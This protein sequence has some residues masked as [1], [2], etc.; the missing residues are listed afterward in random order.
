MDTLRPVRKL[1]SGETVYEGYDTAQI[2]ENG[3]VITRRAESDPRYTE[4]HCSKCGA[5]TV[6]ACASCSAKIR[7]HLHGTMPSMHEEP[8]PN[9]CH[10]CGKPYPWI[11]QKLLAATVLIEEADGLSDSEK[12][13]LTKSLDDLVRDVPATDLPVHVLAQFLVLALACG[14]WELADAVHEIRQARIAFDPRLELV[15]SVPSQ[16]PS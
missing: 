12:A 8:A 16:S 6:M 1:G 10:K 11:E 3:H 7:G 9:F 13:A 4:D 5:K 15:Q 14:L 2:C